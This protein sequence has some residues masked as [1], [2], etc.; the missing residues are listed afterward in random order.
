MYDRIAR[1]YDLSHDRLTSDIQFLLDLAAGTGDPALELGCGS[2]RLLL[3]LARNGFHVTGVDNSTEMLAR[4]RVRLTGEPAEVRDRVE[5]LAG[6]M[7]ALEL[8]EAGSRFGLAFF[9]YNTFMH[10]DETRAGRTMRRLP[11]LLRPDGRLFI[12]VDNPLALAAAADDPDFALEEEIQDPQTGEFV[13]QY[14]AYEAVQGEQAVDVT[15]V[16]ETPNPASPTPLHTKARLR[17]HYLYPHQ[18]DL[19][20]G[21]VGLRLLALYGDYDRTPYREDSDRLLVVAG[22]DR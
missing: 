4:A 20:L 19:M 12:D 13:R 5:L 9:G 14:T 11:L 10:L 1:Y 2:G 17:Y 15:W 3:P 6:D 7:A 18:I 22:V 21:L 8:P 16:Y